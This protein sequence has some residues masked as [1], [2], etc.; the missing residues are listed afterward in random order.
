MT[1]AESAILLAQISVDT[2]SRDSINSILGPSICE[3]SLIPNV[4]YVLPRV[5]NAAQADQL[6]HHEVEGR[7]DGLVKEVEELENQRGELVDELMNK[8]VKEVVET[9]KMESVQDMSGCG[10]NQKVKYTA[11]S[12]IGKALAWW[13][14]HIQT[15]GQEAVVGMTWEDFKALMR[16]EFCLNNEMKKLETE[17]W[18]HAMVGASHAAYTDR[19]HELARQVPYLVTLE[20]KSIERYIYDLAPQIR[21]MVAVMEPTTIQ[22]AILKARVLIDEAIRNGSLKK[23][24]EKRGNGGEPSRDGNVKDDNKRSKTGRVF[25]TTTNPVRKEY[26]GAAPKCTNCNFHH[27]PKM[28]YRMCTNCNRLGHF[29]KD[30]RAGP[31]MV[32]PLNPRNLIAARGGVL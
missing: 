16:D 30:C 28:P 14:S 6:L 32:N 3:I 24:T 2:L 27:N 13:N 25:A 29:A 7:V 4:T 31:R 15:K 10:D 20:K 21:G 19:F 18:C 12:F 26:T 5:D 1:H 17:F 11:G 23:N 22:S 9:E 8:M